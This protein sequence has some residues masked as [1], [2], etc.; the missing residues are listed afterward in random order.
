MDQ[1]TENQKEEPKKNPLLEGIEFGVGG[2][3]IGITTFLL[4][5]FVLNYFNIV[6]LSLVFPKYFAFLPHRAS[7]NPPAG[8]EG[9]QPLQ[10]V[11][12]NNPEQSRRASPTPT[13]SPTPSFTY[14]SGLE[15]CSVKKEGNPLVD[16]LTTVKTGTLSATPQTII[17]GTFRG[18]INKFTYDAG[19]KTATLEL[20][21][22]KGDQQ[23]TFNLKEESGLVHD[24][25]TIT[26]LT[27][28][29]LKV[30]QTVVI[31]FNCYPD[32]PKEKQFKITRV[33]VTGK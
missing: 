15:S 20:I 11:T 8:G 1:L 4:M 13:P 24:A 23:H 2:A 29:D 5:L 30:G 26:N 32:Q 18:N 7:P 21:A 9:G 16:Y 17:V 22:P 12:L 3:L 28:A 31:S 19:E 33:A 6:S 27:L 25:T 10:G 14:A